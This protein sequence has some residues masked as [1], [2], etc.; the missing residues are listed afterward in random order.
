M[1]MTDQYEIDPGQLIE[2]DAR[3]PV[4]FGTSPSHWTRPFRPDRIRQN[5]KTL[6]LNQ[7]RRM[8]D[9]CDRHLIALQRV[10]EIQ[11]RGI[12]HPFWP[13]L[14]PHGEQHLESGEEPMALGIAG[15]E[16]FC[17]IVMIGLFKHG[18]ALNHGRIWPV[19]L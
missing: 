8:I 15:I 5:I 18:K 16:E 4:S 1:I 17:A 10:M 14:K 3:F 13:F 7:H 12:L 9:K 6:R 11:R 19:K 2:R